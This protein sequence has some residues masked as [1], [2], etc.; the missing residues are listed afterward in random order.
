MMLVARLVARHAYL[1]SMMKR[2]VVM[3]LVT[4]LVVRHCILTF[5][6]EES[7]GDDAGY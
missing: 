7:G 3:T 1:R 6:D 4:R 5:N 2:V